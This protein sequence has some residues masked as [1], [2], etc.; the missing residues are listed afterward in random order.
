[1]SKKSNVNPDHYKLRGRDRQGEDIRQ[2]AERHR[3][4]KAEEWATRSGGPAT[5]GGRAG[6]KGTR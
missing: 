6:R 4:A 2:T 3:F 5:R 1:M